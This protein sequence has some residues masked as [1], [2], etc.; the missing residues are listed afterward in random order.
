MTSLYYDKMSEVQ[1]RFMKAATLPYKTYDLEIDCASLG[2]SCR[3]FISVS[4]SADPF[5][6]I[7]GD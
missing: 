7:V 6:R 4:V 1:R 5:P 2:I 3:I